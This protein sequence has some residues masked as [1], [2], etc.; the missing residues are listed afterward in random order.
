MAGVGDEQHPAG[1]GTHMQ[2]LTDNPLIVDHRLAVVDAIQRS[3]VDQHLVAEGVGIHRQQLGH[4][5]A[6]ILV[7]RRAEQL[8][9]ALVLMLQ[10]IHLQQA[11]AQGEQLLL[12]LLGLLDEIGPGLH[13]GR[14]GVEQGSGGIGHVLQRT[15]E[16]TQVDADMGKHTEAR[17]RDD[18][19]NRDDDGEKQP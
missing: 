14:H 3:L 16:W 17:V 1:C 13:L 12:L 8:A 2:H 15:D 6:G 4:H 9:Q 7:H 11:R 5:L 18:G 19:C 10:M